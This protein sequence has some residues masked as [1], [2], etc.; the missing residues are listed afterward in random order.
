MGREATR[1]RAVGVGQ[2]DVVLIR[3]RDRAVVGHVRVPRELDGLRGLGPQE[4][5]GDE[6]R[7]GRALNQQAAG[8]TYV[9]RC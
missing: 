8:E 6:D 5:R 4:R 1:I 3:E 7:G 9:G 2:P